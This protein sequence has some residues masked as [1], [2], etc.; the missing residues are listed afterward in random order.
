M[1]V[2]SEDDIRFM[3]RALELA[4][5]GEGAVEPNPMVGCVIVRD[6]KIIGEGY[7]KAFGGSHAEVE[8]IRSAAESAESTGNATL[9]VTLEPC[10]HYGKTPPCTEAIFRTG[11]RRI[12]AA[13][14]DPFPPVD[15]GG[16]AR[17]QAAGMDVSL[18][19]LADEATELNAPYL[20]RTQ[21]RRP[22]IH[23]KWAMTLD[24]K[25]AARTGSSRWITS[26]MS[27]EI[28][29]KIRSRMD[30]V[31]VGSRTA[32]IDDP[33]LTVRL[34]EGNA[35]QRMP[36]R[37]VWDSQASLPPES[38]LAQ[39]AKDIPVIVAA[40]TGLNDVNACKLKKMGCEILLLEEISYSQRMTKLLQN[41]ADRG[42]TNLLME[43]GG[44]LL[45]HLF[46]FCL[47]DECHIFI[48]PKLIGGENAVTPLGGIGLEKMLEAVEIPKMEVTTVGPD[49]YLHGRLM[50]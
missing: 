50:R 9:Y 43:G 16:I 20:M 35:P 28:V 2:F 25:I 5:R 19:C 33:L 45:G 17:L 18:G 26:E 11:I 47:I 41:L 42:V 21:Q 37:V 4:S 14:R 39:T 29:H 24:G 8:A 7:H 27:R 36:L 38:Q 49:V 13:M 40:G 44:T 48:A 3:R 23:A 32:K 6:G 1:S 15:G 31:M 10:C 12:V 34:P 22:W 30:A 46:D